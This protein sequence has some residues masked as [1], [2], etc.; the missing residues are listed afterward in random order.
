MPFT[1]AQNLETI[2]R[3]KP[4]RISG[5]IS[6]NQ[7]F[8]SAS[9]I[10][11]RRDPYSYFLSG[12]LNFD[13]YGWSMPL[14]FSFS[15]QKLSFQQPF[16]QYGLHPTYKWITG[17]IG[18]VSMNFS[19]YTLSGH[20]FKGV[21]VDVAPAGKFTYSAMYGRLQ[22]AVEADSSLEGGG[23][24]AFRRMGY[25]FKVGY[26][27]GGDYANAILF[28]AKDEAGSLS[29]IPADAEIAPQENLVLSIGAGKTFL[30]RLLLSAELA[31]SAFTRDHRSPE[32]AGRS[33]YHWFGNLYTPRSSSTYYKAFKSALSY[34][35]NFYTVGLGYERIDPEYRTLGAYYFNNDL[36]NLTV[37][38]TTALFKGKVSLGLNVGL[39][40][41]NLDAEKI[42]TMRRMVG[43]ASVGYAASERLNLNASYSNFQTFTNIRPQFEQQN[44]LTPYENLDTLNFTQISQSANLNASYVL[45][46]DKERRQNLSMNLSFQDAAD[47]QGNGSMHAG[48]QFYNL[49][50][51]YSMNLAPKQMSVTGALNYSHNQMDTIAS[52]AVGP[53]L[54]S[55]RSFFEKKLRASLSATANNSYSNGNLQSRVISLRGSSSYKIQKQHNFNLS[56]VGLNRR[57]KRAEGMQSFLEFTATLGYSYNFGG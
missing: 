57:S 36:E 18:F 14:S 28:R 30:K 29:F 8:Y 27:N 2:G 9:G 53:T 34:R 5:G 1:S 56:L 35:G 19:P 13:L 23:Q 55:S 45:S 11:S 39:Q 37:N 20:L 47:K 7:I 12:N 40:Q 26:R 17:H 25:G 44:Q 49:N 6:A 15:N 24:A 3:E 42:S 50:T 48:T 46:A 31:G 10:D 51:A 52:I 16:N 54:A 33:P 4:L 43:S 22:K 32:S 38:T 41:N 21:G